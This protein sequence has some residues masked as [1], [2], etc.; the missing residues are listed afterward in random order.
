MGTQ[1]WVGEHRP[2]LALAP[3]AKPDSLGHASPLA[4]RL[5]RYASVRRQT[6]PACDVMA[7][8][9]QPQR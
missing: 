5:D 4:Q 6:A 2:Q 7:G 3:A 9:D 1:G 8:R